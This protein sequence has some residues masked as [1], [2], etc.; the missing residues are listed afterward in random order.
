MATSVHSHLQHTPD[1]SAPVGQQKAIRG[2]KEAARGSQLHWDQPASQHNGC[3]LPAVL[4][5]GSA[6]PPN[7]SPSSTP[8]PQLCFPSP[9]AQRMPPQHSTAQHCHMLAPK[10]GFRPT[11]VLHHSH[12]CLRVALQSFPFSTHSARGTATANR[13]GITSIV[14][15]KQPPVLIY[16]PNTRF[17]SCQHEK[18]HQSYRGKFHPSLPHLRKRTKS[19]MLLWLQPESFILPL[20]R[21]TDCKG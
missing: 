2:Q 13:L 1:C 21:N 20:A 6:Q 14:L 7:P 9:A 11:L 5:Q 16:K 10:M 18:S 15:H 19:N 3:M 17:S 8:S 12:H 4:L